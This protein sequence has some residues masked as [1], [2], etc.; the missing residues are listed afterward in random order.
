MKWWKTA[1]VVFVLGLCLLLTGCPG[2]TPVSI[3]VVFTPYAVP[4]S[5]GT[6]IVYELL[7]SDYRTKNLEMKTVEVF[8]DGALLRT[9]TDADWLRDDYT[10]PVALIF[11]KEGAASEAED[12]CKQPVLY[13]AIPLTAG[14]KV[15]ATLSHKIY[16]AKNASKKAFSLAVEGGTA[17]MN[18]EP[19]PVIAPPLRGSRMAITEAISPRTHHRTGISMIDGKPFI[20]QRFAIDY[21]QLTEQGTMAGGDPSINASYPG[22][23]DDL[24]AVA[25]G[26]VVKI[27]CGV[28][29]NETPPGRSMVITNE[30]VGGNLVVI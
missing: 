26:K 9:Y 1:S 29:D 19:L 15:P 21:F 22:Y 6:V 18:T 24:L 5:D 8:A 10:A 12:A 4:N 25:P 16:F 28:V 14:E 23:G 11:P 13:F 20:S 17:S 7:L 3:A 27:V 30:I 2:K